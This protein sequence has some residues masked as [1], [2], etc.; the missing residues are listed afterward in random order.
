MIKNTCSIAL[1]FL[2]S[3]TL[4]AP[5]TAQ[6]DSNEDTINIFKQS[7]VVQPFFDT[8]YGYAVFPKVIKAGLVA[9]FTYGKGKVYKGGIATG[10]S[11]V[12]R[13][14]LGFQFGGLGMR[15]IVFFEDERAYNEFTNE[16]F[17]FDFGVNATVITVAAQAQAGSMGSTASASVGPATGAQ[18]NSRYYK[19]MAVFV[20][21]KGGLMLEASIGGQK[22]TFEPFE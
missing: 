12:N 5:L 13:M 4:I 2:L 22:F 14:S 7:P 11:S 6:A 1:V 21:H 8:A 19:G 3:V 9:G 17:N 10:I 16:G 20:H 15:Q 18:A